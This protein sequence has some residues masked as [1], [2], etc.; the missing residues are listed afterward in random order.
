MSNF[1]E[2]TAM[3]FLETFFSLRN[4]M[5]YGV[6]SVKR[7]MTIVNFNILGTLNVNGTLPMKDIASMLNIKKSNL[8]KN[9]DNL[10]EHKL[11]ERTTSEKDRRVV[12]ISLT[13]K[14]KTLYSQYRHIFMKC[15]G[16]KFDF[17]T[18]DELKKLN[19]ALITISVLM[20]KYREHENE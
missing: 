13:E 11:V 5:S 17:F 10:I 15:L 8:T 19:N 1:S 7:E 14:G 4:V 18:E 12:Y 3:L 2:V 9:I 6:N 20:G 16:K